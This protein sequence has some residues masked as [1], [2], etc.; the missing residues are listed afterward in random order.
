MRYSGKE[1]HLCGITSLGHLAGKSLTSTFS[2]VYHCHQQTNQMNKQ[3]A[4]LGFIHGM[5]SPAQRPAKLS[6]AQHSR[7]LKFSVISFLFQ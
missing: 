7:I 6:E 3:K 4:G 1:A 2:S 5:A